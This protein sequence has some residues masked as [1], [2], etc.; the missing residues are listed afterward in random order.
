VTVGPAAS[1]AFHD[2]TP[3]EPPVRGFLHHPLAPARGG[4]VLTHGAGSD[5]RAPLLVGLAAALAVHRV[6]VLRCDLSYRQ[7]RRTGPPHPGDA[8]RDRHG[9]RRAVLL[10]RR[11]WPGPCFLGG[12]SYGG[13]QAS[14]LAAEEP[15]LVDALL[16]L[17]YPLHP[18]GRATQPRT[19]HFP[20]LRTPA[21]LAHGSA[22]PFGTV[23]EL[24]AARRLIPARTALVVIEGAG[25]GLGRG[26]RVRMP[27]SDTLERVAGEFLALAEG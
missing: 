7:A 11:L 13:R 8:P 14:I 10:L 19:S 24:E 21:L 23:D 17:S 22:D 4:L 9:L 15:G 5:C 20:L 2:A 18:P 6:A 12:L 3:G 16:L 1:E 25:H 27:G 26:G